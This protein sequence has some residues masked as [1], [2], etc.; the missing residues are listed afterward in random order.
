MF[1]SNLSIKRITTKSHEVKI[2]QPLSPLYFWEA[3]ERNKQPET[4]CRLLNGWVM[5]LRSEFY[6]SLLF[7]YAILSKLLSYSWLHLWSE[8]GNIHFFTEKKWANICKYAKN[9]SFFPL[10][11]RKTLFPRPCDCILVNEVVGRN[12][13]CHFQV[14]PI[15]LDAQF[16]TLF[17][18]F[19]S[20]RIQ[21]LQSKNSKLYNSVF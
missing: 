17:I 8:N 21:R 6:P 3:Q 5:L 9:F 10:A 2:R 13:V 1:L 15:K 11:S 16:F 4:I 18:S 14:W 19:C 20:S 7:G 12:E